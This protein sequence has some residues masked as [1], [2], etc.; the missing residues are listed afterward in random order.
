MSNETMIK[1]LQ[2][3]LDNLSDINEK[4]HYKITEHFTRSN[5]YNL[6]NLKADTEDDYVMFCDTDDS[7]NTDGVLLANDNYVLNGFLISSLKDNGIHI[8]DH[9]IEFKFICGGHIKIEY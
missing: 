5:T 4:V 1:K 3:K 8:T 2:L 9:H 6:T 7:H